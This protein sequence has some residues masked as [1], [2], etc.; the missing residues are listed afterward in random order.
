MYIY[1][2]IY[3]HRQAATTTCVQSKLAESWAILP[4]S[5]SSSNS[6]TSLQP[7][8]SRMGH[9]SGNS[10]KTGWYKHVK[11]CKHHGSNMFLSHFCVCSSSCSSCSCFCSCFCSCCCCCCSCSCCSCSCSC[12]CSCNTAYIYISSHFCGPLKIV[13]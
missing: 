3:I 8:I 5:T 1:T 10:E 11:T 13:K 2:H 6:L 9:V 4:I 7:S 12:C